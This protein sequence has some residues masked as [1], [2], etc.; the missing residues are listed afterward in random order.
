M[1]TLKLLN[2]SY[3]LW[4][5]PGGKASPT[6]DFPLGLTLLNP[7]KINIVFHWLITK[8]QTVGSIPARTEEEGLGHI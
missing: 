1:F 4:F 7:K 6:E 5:C 3:I 2:R 8:R